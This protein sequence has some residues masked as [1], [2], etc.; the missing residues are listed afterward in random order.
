MTTRFARALTAAALAGLAA[1]A[2]PAHAADG[3]LRVKPVRYGDLDLADAK[4]RA[5]L[6]GR[7]TRAARTVCGSADIRDVRMA[8]I[9][10]DCQKVALDQAHRAIAARTGATRLASVADR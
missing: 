2:L 3:E 7:L 8:A 6:D 1:T 5:R 4:D 9:A 10:A